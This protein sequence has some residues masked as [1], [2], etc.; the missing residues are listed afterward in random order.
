MGMLIRRLKL[1]IKWHPWRFVGAFSVVYSLIWT[2]LES[3]NV[4]LNQNIAF[5]SYWWVLVIV[6]F[7]AGVYKT[8]QA[9]EVRFKIKATNTPVT[10]FFGD[11][12]A[13]PGYKVI[14]VNDC[15]D[16]NVRKNV[17]A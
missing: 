2:F 1:G 14:A 17:S 13:A 4:L 8:P 9:I 12:F 6:S 11:L 5:A 3:S 15:F 16:N 10:I 7:M